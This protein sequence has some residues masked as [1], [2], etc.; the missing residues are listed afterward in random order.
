M[1]RTKLITASIWQR[2]WTPIFSNTFYFIGYAAA[3]SLTGFIF[4]VIAA[5]LLSAEQVGL[6]AAYLNAVALITILGDLGFSVALLRYI[7]VMREGKTSYINA[8]LLFNACTNLFISIVFILGIPLWADEILSLHDGLLGSTIMVLTCI[9]FGLGLIIDNIFIAHQKTQFALLRSICANLLKIIFLIILIKFAPIV[10]FLFSLALASFITVL[11]SVY[12]LIP[13]LI[14]NFKPFQHISFRVLL[15]QI[16]FAISNYYVNI[17]KSILPVLFPLIVVNI[18]GPQS[19]AYFYTSW[20]MANFLYMIPIAIST[21]AFADIAKLNSNYAQKNL[22]ILRLNLLFLIPICVVIIYISPLLFSIFGKDY[23]VGKTL[24]TI[25]AFSVFPYSI[26]LFV[27]NIF[28][29]EQK[30]VVLIVLTSI[31]SALS[32]LLVILLSDFLGLIGIG[33][34]W[35]IGNSLGAIIGLYYVIVNRGKNENCG[36]V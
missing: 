6:G 11:I 36:N 35:F 15:S 21:S 25:L 31:T 27:L 1:T 5:R 26:N 19:N 22:K 17:I 30:S 8:V 2:I 33:Y 12:F 23:I 34:G 32:L 10:S 14:S 13:I 24:F 18:L 3:G 4:W 9:F 20:M 7:P 16:K 28:R 29:L